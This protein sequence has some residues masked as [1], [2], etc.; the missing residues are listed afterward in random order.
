MTRKSTFLANLT[1]IREQAGKSKAE[2][3]KDSG[4][5]STTISQ[6]EKQGMRISPANLRKCYFPLCR[7]DE[8]RL[9]LLTQWAVWKDGEHHWYKNTPAP[10]TAD[11]GGQDRLTATTE[12]V[13][14]LDPETLRLVNRL[15]PMLGA[16]PHL[17][18]LLRLYIEADEDQPPA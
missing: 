5:L 13:K 3:S 11:S 7:S 14:R 18:E 9:S 12:A 16:N 6:M 4:V 2:L 8:E 17:R 15:A 10:T 1:R